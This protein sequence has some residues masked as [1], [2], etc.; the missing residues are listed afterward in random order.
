MEKNRN[1]IETCLI[2]IAD[3][4]C[5]DSFRILYN[6]YY[7]RLFQQALYYLNNNPDYAQEVVSDVFIALWQSRKILKNVN[8]PDAYCF[9]ALKHAAARYVGKNFREKHELLTENLPDIHI[10]D[11]GVDSELIDKEL[12]E[13]YNE[14]LNNLPPRC[15]E[16]FRLVRE[17]R[18]KYSEVAEILGISPKTVDNQMNKAVKLLYMQLK[19]NLIIFFF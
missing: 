4:D 8:D 12:R 14:A 17:E 9:I 13:K 15:A 16:V 7:N 2:K 5:S 18:K 6:H 10:E 19:D 3:N 11:N 1:L